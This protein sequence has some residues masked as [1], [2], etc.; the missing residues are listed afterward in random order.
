MT[1][2]RSRPARTGDDDMIGAGPCPVV[3][4]CSA[5]ATSR[6]KP[7]SSRRILMVDPD[8]KAM[9]RPSGENAGASAPARFG[10]PFE[11][12]ADE[13]LQIE[14]RPGAVATQVHESRA[15]TRDGEGPQRAFEFAATN[16]EANG[17]A[18]RNGAAGWR[19]DGAEAAGDPVGVDDRQH[20]CDDPASDGRPRD[21]P[22]SP[23]GDSHAA[24]DQPLRCAR[25]CRRGAIRRRRCR[26]AGAARLSRDIASGAN[27]CAAACSPAAPASP[28]RS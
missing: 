5:C 21:P 14:R 12:P 4:A 19:A 3:R 6:G 1:G 9:A 17:S 23:G 15:V 18:S 20:R 26:A 28:A 22:R 13:I 2:T 27:G 24:A 7:P 16:C 25:R 8:M 11:F 10:Q